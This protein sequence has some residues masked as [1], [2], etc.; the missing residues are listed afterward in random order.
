MTEKPILHLFPGFDGSGRFFEPLA[1]ALAPDVETQIH[2]L[3]LEGPQDYDTLVGTFA[4]EINRPCFLLGESF[5]GPLSIRLAATK[6]D[7]VRGLILSTTF[8]KTPFPPLVREMMA[9]SAGWRNFVPFQREFS[10]LFIVNDTDKLSVDEIEEE[11]EKLSPA[12]IQKR[13]EA[14]VH[15]D[16]SNTL[17]DLE[18]KVLILKA[19]KDRVIGTGNY[20]PVKPTQCTEMVIDS[21]HML[22]QAE[23]E[24]C[25]EIIKKFMAD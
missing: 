7:L 15:V 21:P 16:V 20:F 6:P 12:T 17:G 13:A 22:L 3:P 1:A 2:T 19:A 5:S 4:S 8:S 11:M 9:M 24:Q 23:T 25:A 14:C 10:K 18:Q